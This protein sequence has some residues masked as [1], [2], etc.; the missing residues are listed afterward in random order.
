METVLIRTGELVLRPWR[1]EDAPAVFRACQDPEV[2]RRL[3]GLPRPY[4]ISDAEIFV[5]DRAP[6]LLAAG[7]AL[8]LGVFAG[9]DL[10]GSVALNTIDRTA[11]TA[12]LGYWSA[13]WARGRRVTERASRAL[14]EW[15]FRSGLGRI[16]W[17]ATVG[18]HPSRLTALRLGF[19]MIGEQPAPARTIP[20]GGW[21]PCS[22]ATSRPRARTSPSRYAGPPA[23]SPEGTRHCPPARSPC[24]RRPAATCRP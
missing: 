8:H 10:A 12:E 1:D 18:N 6:R 24:G 4:R 5:G 9:D 16:D 20:A 23:R 14:L 3:T 22:P 15:A 2:H 7:S 13:P 17:R 21:P 11:G 19:S